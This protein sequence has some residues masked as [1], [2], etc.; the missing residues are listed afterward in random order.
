LSSVPERI[1]QFNSNRIPAY[2]AL[3]YRAMA[4]DP[5]Y[6]FRGTAHLFY[7]DLVNGEATLPGQPL[8]WVCGDLHIENFGSYK[9]DNR[10]VYFD[11]N[12]FD[13]AN[14]APAS[15]ELARMVTSIFVAL[16]TMGVAYVEAKN[17]TL[18][19]L[20]TYSA[21]LSKG[22]SRY[23]EPQ[24]TK[25]IVRSFLIKVSERKQKELVKER[26]IRKN[27]QLA[28][29]VD[30][31]RLFTI[32]PPLKSALSD[33]INTWIANGVPHR[34]FKT[35]DAGF[36]IAGT[37]SVGVKRYLFLLERIGTERKYLLLDMKQAQP[38]AMQSHLHI[39][40]PTWSSEA[41]RVVSIQERMQNISP[42]LLGTAL[43]NNES[44]V[45]KEMQPTA[46]KINFETLQNRLNDMEDVLENMALLTAS[47]QLR[48]SGR[49][50]AAV[51]D[52]LIAFGRDS[53]WIQS[54]IAYAGQYAHQ[55]KEDYHNYLEAYHAGYF[56]GV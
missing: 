28:L 2:T 19:F 53:S 15:W 50:G 33:Y 3:K 18:L 12:D 27:G 42:A 17:M 56:A 4:R 55:V 14:L 8:T 40:Q 47:A 11:I 46:D 23:I 44:Y 43:F 51:A 22:R 10:L 32:D 35:L 38:S 16:T 52:E 26:T 7:E 5:F 54:I 29:F 30:H 21:V 31:K 45:I 39:Q 36:R 34:R 25:G 13:E 37:G 49:Q 20:K 24:T 1:K 6:F 9:G 48:S 41:E